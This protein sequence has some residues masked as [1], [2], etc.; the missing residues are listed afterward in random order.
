MLTPFCRECKPIALYG[1][2]FPVYDDSSEILKP[3]RVFDV[4]LNTPLSSEMVCMQKPVGVKNSAIFI[5][6]TTKLKDPN[7][8]KSDDMGGWI[9]KGKPVRFYKLQRCTSSGEV[10]GV[11]PSSKSAGKAYKLTRIYYH[12]RGT[13]EF[14]K[15]IFYVNSKFLLSL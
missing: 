9:H 10:F 12:H 11:N 14:R 7:D 15:T 3:A 4:I 13:T 5:V 1:G 6:D 2:K 8:L